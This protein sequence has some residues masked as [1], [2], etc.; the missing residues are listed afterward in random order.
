[1]L[2]K[3][4]K[5]IY[6]VSANAKSVASGMREEV[7]TTR[8]KIL[9]KIAALSFALLMIVNFAPSSIAVK[10]IDCLFGRDLF[11]AMDVYLPEKSGRLVLDWEVVEG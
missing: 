3:S 6:R 9:L 4:P 2:K 5:N 11:G 10:N 8:D 7:I 1:V